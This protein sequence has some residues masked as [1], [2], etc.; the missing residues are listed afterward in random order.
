MRFFFSSTVPCFSVPPSWFQIPTN[1]RCCHWCIRTVFCMRALTHGFLPTVTQNS[2]HHEI[3]FW[4]I[5]SGRLNS[6]NFFFGNDL[7]WMN[8]A[9]DENHV[10]FIFIKCIIKKMPTVVT[11]YLRSS[12]VLRHSITF[13]YIYTADIQLQLLSI[14][15]D[16]LNGFNFPNHTRELFPLNETSRYAVL[17]EWTKLFF[18]RTFRSASFKSHVAMAILL[19]IFGYL[20]TLKL[21]STDMFQ[22]LY[23]GK[24]FATKRHYVFML[25]Q[26]TKHCE[27]S[28]RK[29]S[30]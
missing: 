10:P 24:V 17:I 19:I 26:C 3:L 1:V 30:R 9:I 6:T 28:Q 20:H 22:V 4:T 16:P 7:H 27:Q 18:R 15:S 14:Q 13:D 12:A 11:I 25:L 8:F 23:S 2:T 5:M 29:H 21:V